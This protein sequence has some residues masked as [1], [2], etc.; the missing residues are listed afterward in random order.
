[1]ARQLPTLE[2]ARLRLRELKAED[3]PAIVE[4]AGNNNIAKTTTNIPHPYEEKDAVDWIK[5]AQEGFQNNTQ[6]VFGVELKSKNQFIGGVGLTVNNKFN[7]A[8]AGYWIAEPFWNNG[9]CSE[10][11]SGLL[12][13]GFEELHF[14]KIF[15]THFSENIASGKVMAKN[16]MIKEAELKEHIKKSDTFITLVQYRLTKSEYEKINSN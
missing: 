13:F 11:L 7:R 15:A 8:E 6:F 3:I 12:R 10:A 2:T 14:N 5:S 4:Y 1:M 9:Y 16:G